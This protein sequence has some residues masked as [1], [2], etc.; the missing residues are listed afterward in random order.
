MRIFQPTVTGSNTTTG[1]LHISGPVYFYTL[2]DTPVS[3]ILV[4]NTES[5]Q[6]HY[7]ASTDL[8]I[9]NLQQVTDAG[10]TTT[11]FISSSAG[12]VLYDPVS[13]QDLTIAA[14]DTG[15]TLTSPTQTILNVQNDNITFWLNNSTYAGIFNTNLTNPHAYQLPDQDGT[16]LVT[17]WTG[18]ATFSGS[19]YLPALTEISS[20][21][22][23]TYNTESG[24]INYA[25]STGL[26]TSPFP[27]TGSANI[28]GSIELTGSMFTS[29]AIS[30]SFGPNTVGFYGTASWAQNALTASFIT[31]SNVWGPFGSSSILSA[32][33]ASSSTSASY[34]ATASA[35]PLDTYIQYNKNGLLGAEQHF[36]YIYTSHSLQNGYNTTASGQYSHAEGF[37]TIA[38]GSYQTVVGQYNIALPSQSAFIIG[39]GY[40]APLETEKLTSFIAAGADNLSESFSFTPAVGMFIIFT[41]VSTGIS[42]TFEITKVI[43]IG[44]GNYNIEFNGNTTQTYSNFTNDTYSLATYRRHNLLFASRSWFDVS[45]SNVFLRG[46]PQT[47]SNSI[48]IYDS[49]SGQV[50]YTSSITVTGKTQPAPLDTYIQYNSGSEFGATGSFRFIYTS[51][52]LQQGNDVTAS[53]FWSHAQG[54]NSISSGTGSHAE[55]Y[56]TLASGNYSHAEG[57]VDKGQTTKA[58]GL[59]SH[60]EGLGNGA[61]GVGSHAEGRSTYAY[62]EA[63]HTEGDSAEAHGIYSHAEGQDTRAYGTAS[64]A[65]GYG[66][67]ASGKHSHAAGRLTSASG[68][69][70]SVIGQFNIA[71]TSQS[72]FIIGDGESE[73]TRHN[74]LFVSKSWF[75]V[76]ASNVFLQGLPT[77]SE[78][79]VLTYNSTTGQ[80]FYTASNTVG[81]NSTP[82]PSDTYIQYNEDNTFGAEQYFKYIYTSHSFEQGLNV[83]AIGQYSFARGNETFAIGSTSHTEGDSTYTGTLLGYSASIA[84]GIVTLYE[85]YDNVTSEFNIGDYLWFTDYPFTKVILINNVT[86][87]SPNT[88]ITLNDLSINETST[89]IGNA[90]I[91]PTFWDGD[92]KAGGSTAHTEGGGTHALGAGSH[93]EGN[94]TITLGDHSHSEGKD[95]KTLGK[96]SHAEGEN[97]LA[98]GVGSHAEGYQ[99]A[100]YADY[101]HAEG[102]KTITRFGTYSYAHAEGYETVADGNSAHSEG[103]QTT[104]SGAYTHAEGSQTKALNTGAHSEGRRTTASGVYSH[105]EGSDSEA[106]AEASHAAGLYTIANGSY[107]SVIGQYN[108]SL[109]SQSA[110]I[111]GDGTTDND[112]HN[113]LFVSKSHFEVSASNTYLQGLPETSSLAGGLTYEPSTGQVRYAPEPYKTYVAT[114][115]SAN[116]DPDVRKTVLQNTLGTDLYFENEGPDNY[117]HITSS[118]GIFTS[119]K[120]VIFFN[121][122]GT[123]VNSSGIRTAVTRRHSTTSLR[124]YPFDSSSTS[125]FNIG[126]GTGANLYGSIEIRIYS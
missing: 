97:T 13:S 108:V 96:N 74:V 100:T 20:D 124:I 64:H 7:T 17:P 88:I 111:I 94:S 15:I 107:Q 106:L 32:S 22:I 19:F 112:R 2:E 43:S 81:G 56:L 90:N 77:S 85:G 40:I 11:N 118:V 33:Y 37:N 125:N 26:K 39:D 23:I 126:S 38:T 93:A 79:N 60:A 28:T 8:P 61:H 114:F 76:S 78:L 120:T 103:Y 41:D 72:A 58:F 14:I 119:Q 71:N 16:I 95:T 121:F 116:G 65:E 66:T 49:A 62:G 31:A 55:G 54:N 30:A 10:N 68:D 69:Y 117:I 21:Y 82:A 4:Y 12:F 109:P 87:S 6:V 45:A 122:M 47:S 67:L 25:L 36:R 80:V 63:S 83:A 51:Q 57:G 70:Q 102:F 3:H 9:P 50:F 34:A 52:S 42:E 53:G 75:E 115:T 123:T 110:F 5:G 1:S 89:V 44:G 46:I 99:T 91:F 105:A 48:L 59:Y 101:S 29:G 104:A 98:L 86:F 18:S 27:F 73:L 92:K 84:S 35:A 113:V 24:L